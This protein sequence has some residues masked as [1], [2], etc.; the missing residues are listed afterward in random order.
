ML[1]LLLGVFGLVA[2]WGFAAE[3]QDA[4]TAL[5]LWLT[6]LAA[7]AGLLLLGL[8]WTSPRRGTGASD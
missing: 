6:D 7:L 5:A 2:V 3:P 1:D 8:W 4:V